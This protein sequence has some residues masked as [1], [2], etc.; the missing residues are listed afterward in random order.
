MKQIGLKFPD[1]H[2]GGLAFLARGGRVAFHFIRRAQAEYPHVKIYRIEPSTS[3]V[4]MFLHPTMSYEER[5][6]V[7]RYG[8]TSM[9]S[10]LKRRRAVIEELM[11]FHGLNPPDEAAIGG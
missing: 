5:E 10:V 4:M 11:Q 7:L 3:E 1:A 9:T 2:A 8:Y 6:Q